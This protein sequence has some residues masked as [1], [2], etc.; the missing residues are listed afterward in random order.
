ML[1]LVVGSVIA[2]LGIGLGQFNVW[3][4]RKRS[5]AF[6]ERE[7]RKAFLAGVIMDTSIPRENRVPFY[8]EYI[9]LGGNGPVLKLWAAGK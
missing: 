5:Q 6:V 9:S 2:L 1:E 7:S 3:N 4:E 8:E